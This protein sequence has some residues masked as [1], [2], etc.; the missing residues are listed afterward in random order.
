MLIVLG[1]TEVKEVG[2]EEIGGEGIEVVGIKVEGTS[3]GGMGDNVT[4]VK[5]IGGAEMKVKRV[6]VEVDVLD[7]GGKLRR[8]AGRG[9]FFREEQ[10]SSKR[11]KRVG[12]ETFITVCLIV[13]CVKARQRRTV[14]RDFEAHLAISMLIRSR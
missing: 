2:I 9:G 1:G 10:W 11:E 7:L 4:G 5:K 3:I 14:V 6:E 8:L 12:G 13:N